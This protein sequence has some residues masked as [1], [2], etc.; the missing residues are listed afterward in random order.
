M[1]HWIVIEEGKLDASAV[2]SVG[3]E[4]NRCGRESL[5]PTNGTPIATVGSGIVFDVG[6]K[7]LPAKIRCPHC[8]STFAL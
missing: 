4:C 8:D 3:F 2:K 1:K 6:H 5:L 7:A